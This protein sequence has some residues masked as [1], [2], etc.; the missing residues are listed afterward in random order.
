MTRST[1]AGLQ[2]A[3]LRAE[4][5]GVSNPIAPKPPRDDGNYVFRLE[6]PKE[7]F[8]ELCK[9]FKKLHPISQNYE[10]KNNIVFCN[11]RPTSISPNVFNKLSEKEKEIVASNPNTDI[12]SA[13]LQSV[14]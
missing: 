7:S 9:I 11:S 8:E 12:A 13:L 1:S 4:W 2:K 6:K 3:E 5:S 14:E 10:V